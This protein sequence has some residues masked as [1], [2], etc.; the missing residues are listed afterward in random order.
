MHHIYL[1]KSGGFD[2]AKARAYEC[3]GVVA[4]TGGETS[5]LSKICQ[6]HWKMGELVEN[7][8]LLLRINLLINM[9]EKLVKSVLFS[10]SSIALQRDVSKGG[11]L[12]TVMPE[13]LGK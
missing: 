7:L 6:N 12:E 11:F 3:K 1:H 13:P 9:S 5:T 8:S 2:I 4:G 10:H